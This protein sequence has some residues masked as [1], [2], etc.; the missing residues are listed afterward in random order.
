M[1]EVCWLH[2]IVA[3]GIFS[4]LAFFGMQTVYR[5][6]PSC[7]GKLVGCIDPMPAN[8]SRFRESI[9]LHRAWPWPPIL[10]HLA[11][12]QWHVEGICIS[13]FFPIGSFS[14]HA[15]DARDW[16]FP[17]ENVLDLLGS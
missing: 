1:G 4:C 10:H 16:I 8:T 9:P 2:W 5:C 14:L 13:F 11:S 12:I 15:V 7:C 3:V 17:A 6:R